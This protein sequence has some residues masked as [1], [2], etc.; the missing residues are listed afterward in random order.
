MALRIVGL[1]IASRSGD[2]YDA[3]WSPDTGFSVIGGF[4]EFELLDDPAT[5]PVIVFLD[6]ANNFVCE[7]NPPTG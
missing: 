5:F 7:P 4:F 2:P 3:V 1:P 6:E